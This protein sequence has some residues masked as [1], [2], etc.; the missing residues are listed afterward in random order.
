MTQYVISYKAGGQP[1]WI[2]GRKHC[3]SLE[4]AREAL[5]DYKAKQPN[6]VLINLLMTLRYYQNGCL[7]C[8][9]ENTLRTA[10]QPMS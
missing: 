5:N 3:T 6:S 4:K 8:T 10:I 1:H 9:S 2:I 7:K